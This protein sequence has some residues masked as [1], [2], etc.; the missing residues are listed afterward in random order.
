MIEVAIIFMLASGFVKLAGYIKRGYEDDQAKLTNVSKDKLTYVDS[1]GKMRLRSNN[2][3]VAFETYKGRYV[4]RDLKTYS[5]VRDYT[6]ERECREKTKSK[7]RAIKAGKTVYCVDFDMHRQDK[8]KGMRYQDMETNEIY[9]IRS[10]GKWKIPFYMNLDGKFIKPVDKNWRLPN[11]FGIDDGIK[12]DIKKELETQI[13]L[14]PNE[15]RYNYLW[16]EWLD[17]QYCGK[18]YKN[19]I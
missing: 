14:S 9:V 12:V 18:D 13:N 11:H 8:I 4:L 17:L 16:N 2:H 7:N 10:I 19:E 1:R 6:L 3:I 5:I 15:K